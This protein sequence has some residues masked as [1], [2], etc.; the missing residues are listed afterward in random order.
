MS[1]MGRIAARALETQLLVPH[2][3]SWLGTLEKNMNSGNLAVADSKKWNPDSWP[4]EAEGG[5]CAEAPRGPL[6]HWVVIKD[7]KIANYQLVVPSTWNGPVG[8]PIGSRTPGEIA[9]SVL[10]EVVAVK[11][12]VAVAG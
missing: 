3:E 12:G 7:K 10:A 8:L 2:L 11:N 9:V 4:K 1:T 6:G 5:G